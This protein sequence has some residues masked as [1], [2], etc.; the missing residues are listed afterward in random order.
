MSARRPALATAACVAF[1]IGI[2]PSAPADDVVRRPNI[3]LLLLDDQDAYSP[4]WDA[5]PATAEMTRDRGLTFVRAFAPT[6]ICSPGRVTLISGKLAHNTDVYTLVG[7]TGGWRYPGN[8]PE[9]FAVELDKL[10]YVNA[11][12]GKSWGPA[13]IAPG[14]DVWC[15]L[16]GDRLYEGYGYVVYQ[17]RRGSPLNAFDSSQYSTDFL[18]DQTVAFLQNRANDPTP[19]FIWLAPT[20]PHLPLDP[21]PRHVAY[22]YRRW[23]GQLPRNADFNERDVSDKSSWLRNTAGARSAAVPYAINEYP[24]RMGSLMAVDEMMGRIRDVLEAQGKWEN[25]VVI[26][27]SDNGYNLGAHR[28]IHKMAP[29]EESIRIPLVMAGGGIAKGEVD[30]LVGLH[31]IGPTLITLAGGVW[32]TYMDGKSLDTFLRDG[33]D[34]TIDWRQWLVTEYNSGGVRPG[35]NPG[36]AM[37]AGYAM[38]IPTYRSIRTET[39]KYIRFPGG[40]EELYDLVADPFELKNLLKT[41]RTVSVLAERDRLRALLNSGLRC[42]GPS[43]P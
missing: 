39:K 23:R 3:V 24:K 16:A 27:T 10:G 4:M 21:A 14:F 17:Q 1:L 5:M 12:F 22:A 33:E 7:P 15:S 30:K 32:P 38:D 34:A 18:A 28:L 8:S 2:A 11:L 40:E 43:C 31:D 6:P 9:S 26:V 13:S 41:G 42:E 37:R 35:Y 19:F 25:T 36:G 20:A 29:Y